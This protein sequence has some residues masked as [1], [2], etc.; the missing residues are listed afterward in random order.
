[1]REG[2]PVSIADLVASGQRPSP[3][4][5]VAVVL[6]ICTQVVCHEPSHAVA[7]P[8][9]SKTTFL[10]PSGA[11]I[12]AGGAP[13]EDDQTVP[14]LGH[15]LREMLPGYDGDEAVPP[16][17]REIV[18]ET[19]RA[20][21]A[22]R[23]RYRSV[24][25]LASALARLG[26]NQRHAAVRALYERCRTAAARPGEETGGQPRVETARPPQRGRRPSAR[27][28]A[29]TAAF[30][31]VPLLMLM[32]AGAAYWWSDEHPTRLP[33]RPGLT[34]PQLT[35]PHGQPGRELLQA[36]IQAPARS[37]RRS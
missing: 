36:P 8:I 11:V 37:A 19:T 26:P 1:M 13:G 4:E 2:F 9:S 16:R 22:S 28:R 12:V 35:A 6:E 32:G 34:R 31:G 27:R 17:L 7:R 15:L 10:D 29:A 18:S 20:G 21:L 23:A 24:T 3:A 25:L 30:V 5:A 33:Q 14:L